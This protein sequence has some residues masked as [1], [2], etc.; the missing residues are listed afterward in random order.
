LSTVDRDH[1]ER[2]LRKEDVEKDYGNR[3]P[4]DR[5]ANRNVK[6]SKKVCIISHS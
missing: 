2:E 6:M 5:D 1:S 3:T 4:G